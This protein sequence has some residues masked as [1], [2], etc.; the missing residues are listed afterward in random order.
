[1]L[2]GMKEIRRTFSPRRVIVV[3]PRRQGLSPRR[4][5]MRRPRRQSIW[6][7]VLK[8][9]GKKRGSQ[10]DCSSSVLDSSVIA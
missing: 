1:M 3:L 6:T 10:L 4:V 5:K 2:K 8:G 9:L 7:K